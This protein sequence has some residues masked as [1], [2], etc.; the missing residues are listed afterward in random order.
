MLLLDLLYFTE[1]FL[2]G[3]PGYYNHKLLVNVGGRVSEDFFGR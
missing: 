1:V 3:V 2:G